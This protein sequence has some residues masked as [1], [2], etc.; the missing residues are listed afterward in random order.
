MALHQTVINFD[1]TA[2]TIPQA[3]LLPTM[4]STTITRYLTHLAKERPGETPT[5][6]WVG[7][8]IDLHP[9]YAIGGSTSALPTYHEVSHDPEAFLNP[10]ARHPTYDETDLIVLNPRGMPSI[11]AFTHLAQLAQTAEVFLATNRLLTAAGG[12][13]NLLWNYSLSNVR[14][15][16][17][18]LKAHIHHTFGVHPLC[19][20]EGLGSPDNLSSAFNAAMKV[21]ITA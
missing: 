21:E 7:P 1:A 20:F 15:T 17:S 10:D 18:G 16:P 11:Y 13:T 4:L 14:E 2:P 12:V 8:K 5:I 6:H 3:V 19:N 9:D